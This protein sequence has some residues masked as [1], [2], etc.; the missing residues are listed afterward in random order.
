MFSSVT[1][2]LTCSV[3]GV[4]GNSQKSLSIQQ[5]RIQEVSIHECSLPCKMKVVFKMI[6]VVVMGVAV[7][8][9]RGAPNGGSGVKDHAGRDGVPMA[10]DVPQE[11][12]VPAPQ[13]VATGVP[14]AAGPAEDV[15]EP[16]SVAPDNPTLVSG[17][18]DG[19]GDEP[20]GPSDGD[21]DGIDP[22]EW[23]DAKTPDFLSATEFDDFEDWFGDRYKNY[24]SAGLRTLLRGGKASTMTDFFRLL[25]L[26]VPPEVY[27]KFAED[28]IVWTSRRRRA[29]A[30]E[31]KSREL[32]REQQ[33]FNARYCG[34]IGISPL[35]FA[36]II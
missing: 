21:G 29:A 22:S 34:E 10:V 4:V 9:V 25:E 30:R 20:S 36:S 1:V 28:A 19:D 8:G 3:D 15:V 31:V 11:G 32:E 12:M 18:G 35:S 17:P 2:F 23:F 26:V 13:A 16:P 6:M 33:E 27:M 24:K 5:E 14:A 7:Q